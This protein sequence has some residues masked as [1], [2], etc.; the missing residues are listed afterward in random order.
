MDFDEESILER[1]KENVKNECTLVE[2]TFTM[3]N[4]QAVATELATFYTMLV[5]PLQE[6][7]TN[8]KEEVSVSGNEQ[9]YVQWAMEVT[10][11]EGNKLVGNARAVGVRDGTGIVNVYILTPEGKSP[12]EEIIEQ[13]YS[14]IMERRPV[15]AKPVVL[16]S[17]SL[18]VSISVTAILEDGFSRE[19]VY[20]AIA[21]RITE[22]FNKIAFS[23]KVLNLSYFRLGD[24]LFDVPGIKD[25]MGYTINDDRVSLNS[26]PDKYF[27]LKELILNVD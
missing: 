12:T 7:I 19:D 24:I 13:V 27:S 6:M 2:G 22:Y 10:N 11:S 9:H 15:G 23:K 3:D 1:L 14:Y 18:D 20:S 26:R 8:Y 25:I 4:L 21:N 16:A 5:E 17:E